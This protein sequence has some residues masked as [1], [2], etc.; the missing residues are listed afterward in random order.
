MQVEFDSQQSELNKTKHGINFT[1]AQPLWE[2][3]NRVVVPARTSGEPRYLLIGRVSGT[4]WSAVF[5]L[6]GE[7]VRIIPVR[8]SRTEECAVWT[9]GGRF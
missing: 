5:T 1:A 3:L 2:D 8:R 7:A 9:A 6:R 4:H